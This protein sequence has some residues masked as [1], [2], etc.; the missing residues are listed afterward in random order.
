M[1]TTATLVQS[2]SQFGPYGM[3]GHRGAIPEI[4]QVVQ[5]GE[6]VIVR[7]DFD[8]NAHGPA[9]IGVANRVVTV[10][11]GANRRVELKFTA[12]VTP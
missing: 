2:E 4:N 1:C 5:P 8:P 6:T 11:V 7:A 10:L 12:Y 3:K 9:G